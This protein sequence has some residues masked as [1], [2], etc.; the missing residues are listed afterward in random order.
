MSDLH[1]TFRISSISSSNMIYDVKMTTILQVSSQEPSTSSKSH[2][3][4]TQPNLVG[5]SS[6]FQDISHII[7]QHDLCERWPQ[8]S[9][10]PVRNHQHHPSPTFSF[11]SQIM[12]DLHK[13][14]RISSIS[15]INM[16][17]DVKDD[18][19][20]QVSNQETSTSSKSPTYP[21]SAKSCLIFVKLS[22]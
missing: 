2:F 15:A 11:F 3:L 18:T 7:Y 22:G 14:F 20:L 6:N 10:S 12:S 8:S 4:H 13:N 16:I 5:S 9:K 17:Y 21:F 19:I 1:Q